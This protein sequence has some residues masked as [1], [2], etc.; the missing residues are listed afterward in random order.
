VKTE[1]PNGIQIYSRYR[2]DAV[3]RLQHAGK[4]IKH[5]HSNGSNHA[6]HDT[7]HFPFKDI[8]R[9]LKEIERIVEM[10]RAFYELDALRY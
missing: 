5:Y 4:H 6:T 8:V 9:V 3:D 7:C 2:H 10:E 1:V